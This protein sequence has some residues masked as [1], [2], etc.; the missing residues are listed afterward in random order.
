MIEIKE[1]DKY[2]P[3]GYVSELLCL[4]IISKLEIYLKGVEEDDD[5]IWSKSPQQGKSFYK[6]RRCDK[7]CR[8]FGKIRLSL[9]NNKNFKMTS[10]NALNFNER[11]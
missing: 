8:C 1:E 5:A 6:F 10:L 2:M 11:A 4:D 9:H 3:Q 7:T